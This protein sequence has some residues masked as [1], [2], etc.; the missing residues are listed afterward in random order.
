MFSIF[1]K[2]KCVSHALSGRCGKVNMP[3]IIIIIDI[4]AAINAYK[5]WSKTNVFHNIVT[6]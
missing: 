5:Y 3:Y 2:G 6:I 4:G 1:I